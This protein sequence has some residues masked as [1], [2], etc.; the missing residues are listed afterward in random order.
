LITYRVADQQGGAELA[1]VAQLA[2]LR[3]LAAEA[4][5]DGQGLLAQSGA[6]RGSG[7]RL[8]LLPKHNDGHFLS[9]DAEY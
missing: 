8:N 7:G 6:I 5:Q 3:N 9:F 1:G 2:Y 4:L